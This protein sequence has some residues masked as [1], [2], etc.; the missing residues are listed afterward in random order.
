MLP[1]LTVVR[2]TEISVALNC[3]RNVCLVQY[4]CIALRLQKW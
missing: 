2:G 1:F 4:F 3:Q